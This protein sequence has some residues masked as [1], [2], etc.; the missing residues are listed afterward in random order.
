MQAPITVL[1]PTF[2]EEK[3]IQ[4][5]VH[6]ASFASEIL[7]IDSFSTDR[8]VELARKMKCTVVQRKFDNFS[9]QKNFAISKAQNDWV[10]VLDAD[11]YITYELQKEIVSII[12]NPIH[13]GYKIPF[14]NFF[15]NRFINYG[16]NGK[17]NKLRL[18]HKDY[19][20]YKGLVHEEL[21]CTGSTGT[22][23]GKILHYTFKNLNHFFLKKISYSQLQGEQ[24]FLNKKKAKIFHLIF[25]PFFRFLNEFI[26]RLGFLDGMAGLTS[27]VLNG[28]GVTSRY[29]NLMQ[30]TS[31]F[32]NP[33]LNNYYEYSKQLMAEA[34]IEGLKKEKSENIYKINFFWKPFSVFWK[35]YLIKG[36]FIKGKEG[37]IISYLQSFKAFN[38]ILYHWLNKRNMV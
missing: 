17:K 5:A 14:K 22:M 2:N 26:L 24:L 35:E 23:K 10:L 21:I 18:F 19:C 37:Y 36:N 16:S 20:D 29:V 8:T 1:I 6:S 31:K 12:K 38:I 7:V 32:S 15:I 27:T 34:K 30:L 13:T 33:V 3:Y 28:Y 9:N 4:Q 25:K 11:E